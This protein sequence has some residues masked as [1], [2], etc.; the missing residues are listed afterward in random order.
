MNGVRKSPQ[1]SVV[2][3]TYNRVELLR[4]TLESLTKQRLP[5]ESFEVLV[6]DDGSSDTTADMVDT[7]RQRLDLRYFFQPD[8]GWRSA[9]A[10]NVGIAQAEAEI[11]VFIDSGVLA[12][13]GCLEAHLASHR[14]EAGPVAVVGY[15]YGLNIDNEDA[16]QIIA[17]V[18]VN[19][20]DGTIARMQS[21]GIHLDVREEYYEKYT[22]NIADLP[23][24]WFIFWT[25]NVSVRTDQIRAVGAFDETFDRWGGEDIDLAYRLHRDG[26]KFV[27][28]RQASS[29]H[30]PHHKNFADN[31]RDAETNYL[32][33]VEKYD[34]PIIRLL[35][36][37]HDVD[38]F[39]INDIIRERN[40]P[41][42]ADYLA[43]LTQP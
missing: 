5:V 34:T 13:S 21:Q 37:P 1:C 20:P 39:N 25:A 12:H 43:T 2:I 28:N 38:P 29:I 32:H 30:F 40:L 4:H 24:P 17:V 18:D 16:E 6:V 33:I 9:A 42:C 41:T 15:L 8:Q 7:Y 3:P 31:L 35:L 11:I 27:V 22:E 36:E 19:D 14:A 26:A 23:A 10:R